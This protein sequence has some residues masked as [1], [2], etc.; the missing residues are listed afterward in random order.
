MS[1]SNAN[2]RLNQI[3]SHLT[4]TYSSGLLAGKVAIVTG[5]GQGIGAETAKLFAREGAWVVVADIDAAKCTSVANEILSTGSKALSVPGDV[6]SPSYITHLITQ[7]SQ[8]GNGKIHIIVNNAGYTWDGV[9]HKTS[10]EQWDA[11]LAM[12]TKAPFMLVREASKFFRVKDGED[13]CIINVGSTSGVF[14]NAG[15]ANYATAKA[16]VEGLTKTIA[17]EWGP[18]FSVRCNCVAF[19][20]IQ[21]RLT[22]P[23]TASNTHTITLPDGSKKTIPLG[24]PQGARP[25]EPEKKFANVALRRAGTVQEAAGSILA[26]ASPLMGFVS[27]VT[28]EVT[29]GRI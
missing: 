18:Q 16:G 8:F 24:I 25:E 28:L 10:N 15:Q 17:K 4:N 27:G 21:T 26:L 20:T 6:L 5:A 14:G 3:Q 13:R 7:T 1:G 11:I 2:D 12:H 29:G 9:I 23:K 19:G 22:A